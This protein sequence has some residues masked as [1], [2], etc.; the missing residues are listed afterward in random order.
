MDKTCLTLDETAEKM[1]VDYEDK[2]IRFSNRPLSPL[3]KAGLDMDLIKC[4]L[5]GLSTFE[6]VAWL[7]ENRNFV[8]SKSSVGRYHRRFRTLGYIRCKY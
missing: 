1:L 3:R 6:T 8:S 5:Q 7:K 2:Y 4:Y